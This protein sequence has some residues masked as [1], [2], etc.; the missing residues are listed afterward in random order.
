VGQVQRSDAELKKM[1][2]Q[3]APGSTPSRRT[4]WREITPGQ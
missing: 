3:T 4:S 1:D 2:V